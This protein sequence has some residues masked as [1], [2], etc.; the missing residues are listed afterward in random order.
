MDNIQSPNGQNH[1]EVIINKISG[2]S[3]TNT[4]SLLQA[5]LFMLCNMLTDAFVSINK[6]RNES[7]IAAIK[8]G[9][10]SADETAVAGLFQLGG[11]AIMAGTGLAGGIAG[12]K[13]ATDIAQ[14]AEKR[15]SDIMKIDERAMTKGSDLT[16]EV[17][18]L[19][20]IPEPVLDE[21][22]EEAFLDAEETLS[23]KRAEPEEPEEELTEEQLVEQAEA[24]DKITHREANNLLRRVEKEYEVSKNVAQAEAGK[25][26]GLAMPGQAVYYMSQGLGEVE[27][28]KSQKENV[29]QQV[30]QDNQNQQGN[31]ADDIKKKMDD[32]AKFDP[33]QR[34]S[35][36]LRG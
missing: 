4:Q 22:E 20:E 2:D 23:A 11:G 19:D 32:I 15:S 33:F 35:S 18:A 16:V 27:K 12:C 1:S 10:A 14:A 30:E 21:I 17:E 29:Q 26:Q 24:Q 9:F 25:M 3:S 6:A 34:N 7:S 5:A 28:S 31:T 13:Q 8:A 36:S